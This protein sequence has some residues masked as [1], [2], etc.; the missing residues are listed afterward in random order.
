MNPKVSINKPYLKIVNIFLRSRFN[1]RFGAQKNRL[2]E[3]VLLSTN[4]MHF[5]ISNPSIR[6]VLLQCDNIK[7]LLSWTSNDLLVIFNAHI[8]KHQLILRAI[9][10]ENQL[11]SLQVLGFCLPRNADDNLWV[12]MVTE[13]G[14][15]VDLIK[16][17]QMSWEDRL[18][19]GFL[20]CLLR[21][22]QILGCDNM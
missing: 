14:E 15:S 3:T 10:T 16:L 19:V 7:V 8:R 20:Y 21:S 4:N 9:T 18:R 13:L 1:T 17:L 5:G 2:I 6:L 12:A 11:L 22:L